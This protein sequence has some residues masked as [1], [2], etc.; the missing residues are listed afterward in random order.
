MCYHQGVRAALILVAAVAACGGKP[1]ERAPAIDAG[2]TVTV[3]PPPP[4][5]PELPPGTR[6]LRLIR[7]VAARLGPDESAKRI[8][9]VA[10]DTRVAWRDAATGPGCTKSWY[11]IVPQGWVC[12]DFLEATSKAPSGVEL[13]RLDKGEIV[14]G[15][16]GKVIEAGTYVYSKPGGSPKKN[17]D[18]PKPLDGPTTT[19]DDD[20]DTG[21]DSSASI[22]EAATAAGLEKGRPLLGSVNVRKYAELVAAGKVFWKI[23]KGEDEYLPKSAIREH[24]PS[25]YQGVRLGD[26]TG[27]T[28]PL[29][30]VWPRGGATKVWT[31]RAARAGGSNR[32][33]TQRAAVPI[34]ETAQENGQVTAYRIG[35]GEWIDANQVRVARPEPVP[36]GVKPGERW[37]DVD[38]DQ[39]ILIAYEGD[40]P[41]YATMVSTGLR[42]TPTET[43]VYRV[44]KKVAETD[45]KGLTGEDPYSVATVPWTQFF[46]PEKGLALHTSYWH[47]RFGW[48][49]SHGCVNLAP[50]D[51]RWLYFFTD[52]QVP[53]GWS[54]AAGVV[55]APGSIVRVRSK[56]DPNPPVRGYAQKVDD[57]DR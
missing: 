6:S 48:P 50:L 54:M 15:T 57:P 19:P 25:G 32:Q 43:G 2:A 13:P 27:L 53:P 52:P 30:F 56:A 37:I 5:R 9:T 55:E 17:K 40:L 31:H 20:D 14:P 29:A 28:L 34:L 4:P 18:K 7:T 45:M 39:Q 42:D 51:A 16:Y 47:D 12:G 49:K 11:A 3:T 21:A 24:K 44:W 33:L 22:A 41:V 23:T 36:A 35:E 26:D 8:G 10:Q 1:A 46:S 38:L